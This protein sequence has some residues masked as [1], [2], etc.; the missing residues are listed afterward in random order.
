MGHSSGAFLA[1]VISTDSKYWH[2]TRYNL[3]SIAGF[4]AIG[5]QLD[6]MLPAVPED[7]LQEWFERDNY[8]KIFG[9]RIVFEDANPRT[10]INN[11]MP[12]GLILVAESE[13][14]QPPLLRQAK[15]F[16]DEGKRIGLNLTYWVVKDR[17]HMSTIT[18]MP[19]ENDETYNIVAQFIK[20]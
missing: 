11:E 10:H 7:R 17:T 3:K 15:E 16:V 20:D 12:K 9:S 5:T 6:P 8:L 2:A 1:A 14:F 18:R 4:I 13:Q 19:G